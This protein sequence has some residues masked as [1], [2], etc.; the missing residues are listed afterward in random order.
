MERLF[1]TVKIK[2]RLPDMRQRVMFLD[3]NYKDEY[4]LQYNPKEKIEIKKDKFIEIQECHFV[5]DYLTNNFTHWLEEITD[6][7]NKS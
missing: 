5:T 3:E 1:R 6:F 4:M 7:G 2:D